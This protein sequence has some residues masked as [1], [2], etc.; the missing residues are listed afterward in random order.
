MRQVLRN[1][2]LPTKRG[3]IW[4]DNIFILYGR[5]LSWT[6]FLNHLESFVHDEQ[7]LTL[8]SCIHAA[9][10]STIAELDSRKQNVSGLNVTRDCR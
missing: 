10:S 7:N 9:A 8:P 6:L 5:I 2:F 3:L 4:T 1:F